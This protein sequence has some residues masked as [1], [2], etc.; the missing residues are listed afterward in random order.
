MCFRATLLHIATR[1]IT[2]TLT[3]EAVRKAK[4]LAAQRDTSVSGLVSSLLSQAV[5]DIEDYE[6]M[7]ADEEAAM[8]SGLLRVGAI[9][10]SRD[11]LHRR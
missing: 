5:G 10:C 2:L 8:D 3:D 6:S 4:V 11:D 7:W 1:N 9:T